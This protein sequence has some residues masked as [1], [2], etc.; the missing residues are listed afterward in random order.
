MRP[1]MLAG[2]FTFFQKFNEVRA[3]N[4]DGLL[5][6][7][8]WQAGLEPAPDC[9]GCRAQRAGYFIHSVGAVSFYPGAAGRCAFWSH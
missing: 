1:A 3:G 2:R 5:V 9:D 6:I 4:Q 7:N 8:V